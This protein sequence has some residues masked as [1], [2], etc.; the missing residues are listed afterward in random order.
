MRRFGRVITA[1]LWVIVM[2]LGS[3]GISVARAG[4]TELEP[5]SI[6]QQTEAIH[7]YLSRLTDLGFS[8]GVIVQ[9]GDQTMLMRGYGMADRQAGRAFT[10]ETVF[11]IGSVTKPVTA[12]AIMTLI[13]AGKLKTGD[14]IT[15][16]FDNV[17]PDKKDITIHHLLTH[18]SGFV[19]ALGGDFDKSATR[20][21]LLREA[22]SSRLQW[23]PGTRYDYSNVGFSILAMIIEKV[24]GQSFEQFINEHLFD[25]AGMTR[26]GYSLPKYKRDEL[27][28]CYQN[29]M[30]W[31]TMYDQ[32]MLDDG[33]SWNLRGNGGLHTTLRDLAAFNKALA[34]ERII[35]AEAQKQSLTP[36]VDEGYGDSWYGYGWTLFKTPRKTNLWTHNG[37]DGGGY[38]AE[39]RRYVDEDT[40]IFVASSSAE[41]I[42]DHV[43]SAIVRILFEGAAD[44]PPKV[45]R[46]EA[47]RL[48]S[49]AG[50]YQLKGGGSITVGATDRGLSLTPSDQSSVDALTVGAPIAPETAKELNKRTL[51]CLNAAARGE[52]GEIAKAFG[53]ALTTA[54]VAELEGAQWSAWTQAMGAFKKASIIGTTTHRMGNLATLARVDFERG[55]RFVRYVWGRGELQGIRG[56]ENPP[57]TRVFPTSPDEF[58]AFQ[59][60][61][62]NQSRFRFTAASGDRPATLSILGSGSPVEAV[63]QP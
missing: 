38:S 6:K 56:L 17:P 21:W 41:F 5:R 25:R 7:E 49:L 20:D 42:A 4:E 32:D 53:G 12:T 33:P 40:F 37:G 59:L 26:T 13:D 15:K 44:M 61:Q 8:G 31:G 10:D 50:V 62:R 9:R 34:S 30:P 2:S 48:S 63:K 45:V 55:T 16:F 57:D 1:S 51:S 27:A 24:S 54:E 18:S 28:V 29:G 39:Y 36:H 52:F 47:L 60:G 14:P 19:P 46:L 23:V 11:P 43:G 3:G 58:V 22:M 35:S